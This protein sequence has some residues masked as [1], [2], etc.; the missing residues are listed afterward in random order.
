MGGDIFSIDEQV[1]RYASDMSARF[2]SGL[3][4]DEAISRHN[5]SDHVS[6]VNWE[7][8]AQVKQHLENLREVK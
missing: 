3:S 4:V 5:T 7:Y 2:N 6:E 1:E 8:V